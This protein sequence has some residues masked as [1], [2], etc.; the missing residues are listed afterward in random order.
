MKSK[1]LCVRKCGVESCGVG[2]AGG[3][4]THIA[5]TCNMSSV[6]THKYGRVGSG[7]PYGS[8][9]EKTRQQVRQTCDFF[10]LCDMQWIRQEKSARTHDSVAC[11]PN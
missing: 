5:R 7:T 3:F 9:S 6:C 2:G 10:L 4:T 1:S 8:D 11:T